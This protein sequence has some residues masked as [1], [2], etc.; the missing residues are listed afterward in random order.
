MCVCVCACVRACVRACVH[1]SVCVRVCVCVSLSLPPSL[2]LSSQCVNAFLCYCYYG[3]SSLAEEEYDLTQTTAGS[4][5]PAVI[6]L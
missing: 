2:P 1:V 4:V 6:A 3:S 5:G